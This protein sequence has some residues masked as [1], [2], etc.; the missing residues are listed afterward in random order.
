MERA[1]SYER[2]RHILRTTHRSLTNVLNVA[3]KHFGEPYHFGTP[4]V[5]ARSES[6]VRRITKETKL[7]LPQLVE[8]AERG[9]RS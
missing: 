9:G 5:E 8:W 6:V 7:T 2:A 1:T 3:R 4:K